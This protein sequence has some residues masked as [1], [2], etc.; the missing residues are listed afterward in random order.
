[1]KVRRITNVYPSRER[2]DLLA[3]REA[4]SGL[5]VQAGL[6]PGGGKTPGATDLGLALGRPGQAGAGRQ[7]GRAAGRPVRRTADGGAHLEFLTL[8]PQDR[9]NEHEP[10]TRE[11][12][13]VARRRSRHVE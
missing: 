1:M 13:E 11:L 8:L 4:E 5:H 7:S 10:E 6:Q 2:G 12:S 3:L 9:R